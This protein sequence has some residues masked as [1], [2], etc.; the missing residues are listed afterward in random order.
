MAGFSIGAALGIASALGLAKGTFDIKQQRKQQQEAK[1]QAKQQR[2]E[3]MV[4]KDKALTERKTL[5]NKQRKQMGLDSD[6]ATNSTSTTGMTT[7]SSSTIG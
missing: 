2:L 5:I 6:Y 7:G 3:I 4:E 1:K